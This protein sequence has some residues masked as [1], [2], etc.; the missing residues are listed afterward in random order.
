MFC[1]ERIINVFLGQNEND[2]VDEN[3]WFDC[4]H[5]IAFHTTKGYRLVLETENYMISLSTDGVNIESK[6]E[7]KTYADEWLEET[8]NIWEDETEDGTEQDV[9][10]DLENTLFVGERLLSVEK[11]DGYF[12][13]EFDDFKLKLIPYDSDKDIPWL[14]KTDHWS[15]N[16]VLGCDRYLKRKC[17]HCGGD[18]EI[19]MDFVSDYIVRCKN[20]KKSTWAAMELTEAIEDWNNGELNC[21]ADD[22][23]IE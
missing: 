11:S 7:F 10:V 19:L 4:Y 13:L 16:Y 9:F 17:P 5:D 8:V 15:Y 23:T 20:C 2:D 6:N 22:I 1:D 3:C 14:R 12:I 18:G 21:V